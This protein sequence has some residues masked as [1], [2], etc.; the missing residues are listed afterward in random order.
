[1]IY[2]GMRYPS[3]VL[4]TGK[5]PRQ[6]GVDPSFDRN[7]ETII[8]SGLATS[9]AGAVRVATG[10]LAMEIRQLGGSTVSIMPSPLRDALERRGTVGTGRE[11]L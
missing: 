7:V 8:T 9:F 11:I 2:A 4:E 6:V 5:A 10:L 3:I 1:M